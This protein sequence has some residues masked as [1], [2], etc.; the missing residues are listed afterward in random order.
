MP[1]CVA[2]DDVIGVYEP[3]V[4][5]LGRFARRTS[6]AAEP[7]IVATEGDCYHLNCYERPVG[8]S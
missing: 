1:R 7:G 8:A 5:S 2:C 6:R 4:Y 3:L